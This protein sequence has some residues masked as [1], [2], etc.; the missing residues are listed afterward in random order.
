MQ[1]APPGGPVMEGIRSAQAARR[2]HGLSWRITGGKR[3]G[4]MTARLQGQVA[5]VTGGATGIGRACVET[6]LAQGARV[7]FSDIAAVAA[8]ATLRQLQ[9]FEGQVGFMAADVT[10]PAQ[11]AALAAAA[12]SRWG[13]IDILVGNAGLQS[14]GTVLDT[15][16]QDW[17]TT[18]NVN[19]LGLAW[20]IQAVLP[21]MLQQG[22]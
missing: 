11:C 20:S 17:K 7:L 1:P 21:A 2:R 18:L 16:V 8:E 3:G 13:R 14:S 6:L 15:A 12:L 5:I 19:L 22:S 9:S 4:A 10:E